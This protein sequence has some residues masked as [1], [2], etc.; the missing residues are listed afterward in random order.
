MEKV[1]PA[2]CSIYTFIEHN[3]KWVDSTLAALRDEREFE[4][5]PRCVPDRDRTTP[6][7]Q[8]G[9]EGKSYIDIL[10]TGKSLQHRIMP[11]IPIRTR[12]KYTSLFW[13]PER[14]SQRLSLQLRSDLFAT[15][16]PSVVG[17]RK[18][19]IA[20]ENRRDNIATEL[21]RLQIL[22]AKWEAPAELWNL[23]QVA[24]E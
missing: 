20:Y 13:F 2:A 3:P 22:I 8:Q 5:L 16:H 21:P 7:L 10:Y 17:I 19:I 12:L 14:I 4:T 24:L 11:K 1:S 9:S 6:E 15:Q 23:N 18:I